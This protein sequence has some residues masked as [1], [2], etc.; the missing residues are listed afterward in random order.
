[1]ATVISGFG[2]KG[3]HFEEILLITIGADQLRN[4]AAATYAAK[5]KSLYAIYLKL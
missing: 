3:G 2:R 4:E 1:M 5:M